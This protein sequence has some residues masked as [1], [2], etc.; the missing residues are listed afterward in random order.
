MLSSVLVTEC[1][2]SIQ[3][4]ST[5]SGLSCF[6]VRLTGC[7]LRCSYCDTKYA[8]SGGKEMSIAELVDAWQDS[9][10]TVAEITGGEPLLQD[11]FIELAMSL[12]DCS[13][14]QVL[15]ETNG[16]QDI[17][18]IPEGVVGIIDVKCPGSGAEN[19]F[20]MPNISKLHDYD[21]VKFVVRDRDDYEWA[22][23]FVLKYNLTEKC[24]AV[25]FGCV[26][27][28]LDAGSLGKWI[29]DDRLKVRLQVQLHKI[30][31]LF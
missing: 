23:M 25:L 21:E 15:V 7:N 8:Y 3:G 16:S 1:F 27:D 13:E 14:R 30:L 12:R 4:E 31:K 18:V 22:K 29:V 24:N 26:S 28:S 10:A 19:S 2:V 20:Y 9:D 11:G 17:G 5:Y 6:F